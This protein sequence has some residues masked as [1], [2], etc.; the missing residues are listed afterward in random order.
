MTFAMLHTMSVPEHLTRC[1]Q[2]RI[3]TP[4]LAAAG[5]CCSLVISITQQYSLDVQQQ[6]N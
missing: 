3:H 4:A 1:R 6:S 5:M 2:Q